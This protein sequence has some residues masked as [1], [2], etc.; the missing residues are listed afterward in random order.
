MSELE[1]INFSDK[2]QNSGTLLN[3]R[4]QKI[5]DKA[6]EAAKKNA[7]DEVASQVQRFDGEFKQPTLKKYKSMK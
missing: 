2:E 6:E 4:E 3:K 1:K 5:A 7:G